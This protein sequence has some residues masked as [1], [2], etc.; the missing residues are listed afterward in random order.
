MAETSCL[1]ANACLRVFPMLTDFIPRR[2][3]MA[4]RDNPE[5]RDPITGAPGAHPVGTGIG[6][7]AGGI[8][9]G[10][11][12]GTMAA[13]PLGTAVGA[14]IGAVLGGLGGKAVAEQIDPTVI[15][16]HWRDRYQDEPY[17]QA[18]MTY[19]DYA[20]A[21]YFGAASRL[22]YP[23]ED[24]EDTESRLA[25]QYDAVRG[26][27]RLDWEHARPAARAEWSRRQH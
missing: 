26:D 7:A 21:Y 2:F 20:P 24:F 22:A 8:A 10:A 11:A 3:I 9:A 6:A 5:N 18:D 16:D 25:S 14:A 15:D 1:H 17:Y 23:D 12:A 19:D 27:S 4:N 13:G